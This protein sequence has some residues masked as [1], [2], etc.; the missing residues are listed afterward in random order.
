MVLYAGGASAPPK[1]LICRKSGQSP[2]KFGQNLWKFEQNHWKSG[3]KW[4]PTL[5]DFEKLR[6]GFAEKQVQ[7]IFGGH[8]MK[9]VGKCCTTAFW[10]IWENSGKNPLP[11][12]KFA[13]S[14]TYELVCRAVF[15]LK[16]VPKR[17]MMSQKCRLQINLCFQI[18]MLR[19]IVIRALQ[20][21]AHT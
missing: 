12:Q 19:L 9:T 1:F 16:V 7:T 8:T 3:Q 21:A 15:L 10:A 17:I 11:L 4:R 14:Y 2:W 20:Y 13:C 6:P 5:F 18:F